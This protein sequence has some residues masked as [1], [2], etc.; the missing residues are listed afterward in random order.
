VPRELLAQVLDASRW[1]PSGSNRQQWRVTVAT[2]TACQTLADRL[3]EAARERQAGLS[4]AAG[5]PADVSHR[6]N[7]LRAD[8]EHIAQRLG[9]S[10]WEFVVLGSNRLYGAPVVVVVSHQSPR[11]EDATRFVTTML[12]AAHDLG[13]GSCWL[14]YPL[15]FPDVIREVLE[16]PEGE[17]IH[18]V[19]ALGYPDPDSPASAYR[20]PRVE[21]EAFVRWVGFGEGGGHSPGG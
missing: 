7:A 2:G 20:S 1:A 8:L 6:V 11:G 4:S 19:V 17:R 21:L 12:L 10:L 15:G 5:S 14:G 13:L 3:A 18:A 9:Q 16:I